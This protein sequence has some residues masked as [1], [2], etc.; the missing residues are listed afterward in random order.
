[1]SAPIIE[2]KD[3]SKSFGAQ[4]VLKNRNVEVGKGEV[5]SLLG[6]NGADKT[7]VIKI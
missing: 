2:V 5:Y 7:T 6:M 3:L 4:T 1:M